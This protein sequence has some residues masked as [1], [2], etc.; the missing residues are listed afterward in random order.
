MS[1]IFLTTEQVDLLNWAERLVCVTGPPGTGKTILL[2]LIG[3]RWLRRGK[4]VHV[5]STK[6]ASY[7]VCKLIEKQLN[8]TLSQKG[9]G[10]GQQAGK[11]LF[12]DFDFWNQEADIDKAITTLRAAAKYDELYVLLDEV[13]TKRIR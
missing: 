5:V 3:L 8:E 12:H 11:V 4:D 10:H 13:S 6:F 1:R 2:V 7:A 9:I